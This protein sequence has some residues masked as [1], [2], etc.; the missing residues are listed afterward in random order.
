MSAAGQPPPGD[1]ADGW[2]E[3][4]EGARE[5]SAGNG[6]DANMAGEHIAAVRASLWDAGF[7]PIP[8][9]SWNHGKPLERGKRPLAK[10]WTDD[11]RKDPPGCLALDVVAWALNTGILC[12]TLRPF[13]FDIDD[14]DLVARC[15]AVV[16]QRLGEAPLRYRANS[17]RCLALY[18]AAAGAPPKLTLAGKLGKVEVLGEGQ[19]FVAHG[20]HHTNSSLLWTPA[21]PWEFARDSLPAVTE[22]DIIAVLKDLMP[23]LEATKISGIRR[24]GNGTGEPGS[25]GNQT[26]DPLRIAQAL[27]DIPNSEGPSD[28]EWWNNVGLAVWAATGGSPL[29][30]AAFNQWS[31]RH[32]K[33]SAEE[34][35][36]RWDHYFD[37]PPDH[38][39]AGKLFG[40]AKEARK[41]QRGNNTRTVPPVDASVIWITKLALS[42]R[43]VPIPD[44]AN[45]TLALREAPNLAGL[46]AYD[47]MERTPVLLRQV[48]GTVDTAT[49]HPLRDVD[50]GAIQEWVQDA[51]LRRL[52]KDTMHQA[53]ELVA[54]E[55]PFHPVRDYLDG[56]EW[57]NTP[58]LNT[59]LSYYFGVQRLK[60]DAQIGEDYVDAIGR[61]FLISAVARIFKP[62]CQCDY[63][64]VLEGPQGN[65]KSSA[66]GI[67]ADRWFS[68]HL[69]DLH[70][71]PKD[72]SQH[73]NGKWIVE[74]GEL[75]ALL[76]ADASAIK[77][78]ITRRVERYR[79]SYGRRDTFEPRQCVFVGTTNEATYLR[80]P[81]G[82]RR[83]WPVVVVK[84]DLDALRADRDQLWAEAVH[85]FRQ[86]ERWWPTP[87][88][89]ARVMQAEQETRFE[90][91]AWT[92]L[93]RD[94]LADG[95]LRTTI[96]E[97]AAKIGF[98]PERVSTR[99]QRR[100]TAI[101]RRLGWE[102]RR[103]GK[104]RWWMPQ[105]VT[106]WR[107]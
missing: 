89:E 49:P 104:T 68:D 32:P 70:A 9:F 76:K 87:G 13:D 18:R 26:A 55:H 106:R 52:S 72:V 20:I 40:M 39:G 6:R 11:A 33:Y 86:G 102:L 107:E 15:R 51:A 97:V 92:D 81:T 36:A 99:D 50:V 90:E 38:T 8:V 42:D 93:I 17:P 95:K 84:I 69:P 80:D 94:F 7:R 60:A 71:N 54:H 24:T 78:F 37:S 23:L 77:S 16:F 65:L 73:L 28:W 101:M 79:R 31:S 1:D 5:P 35:R 53:A 21:P 91:D 30:F 47:E 3:Y 29:G 75:A 88:F 64:L 57:D 98:L 103:T 83:F 74:L 67:L 19:Q 10:A 61:M 82:G 96:M 45:A 22:D 85:L 63:M 58:R 48:P 34:T 27:N 46:L 62:G 41:A 105:P 100:I 44:L 14:P 2:A 12:D 4:G 59:W 43:G 66:V 25:S 56:L